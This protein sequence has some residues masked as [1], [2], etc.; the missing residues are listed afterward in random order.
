MGIAANVAL[1]LAG[2]WVKWV[3]ANLV[4]LAGGSTQASHQLPGVGTGKGEAGARLGPACGRL[5]AASSRGQPLT[6]RCTQHY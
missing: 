3:N 2:S 1:V 4:P 5:A 6:Q